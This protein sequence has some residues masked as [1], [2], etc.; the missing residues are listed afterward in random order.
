MGAGVD[1]PSIMTAL[2]EETAMLLKNIENEIDIGES[3]A[4]TELI[5]GQERFGVGM[6]FVVLCKTFGGKIPP[7]P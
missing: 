1:G 6:S 2:R 5:M 3:E 4:E 7:A